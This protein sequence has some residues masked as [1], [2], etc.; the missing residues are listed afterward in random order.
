MNLRALRTL[1][2]LRETPSFAEVAVTSN[3]TLSAVSMQMRSLEEELGV[4]LFDRSFRPPRLTPQGRVVAEQAAL[5]AR[6]E[7]RLRALASSGATLAGRYRMGFVLTA[8]VRLLPGFLAR[9]RDAAPGASF[10]V[11]TGLTEALV[12]GVLHGRLD[13]AVVTGT[14]V[15]SGLEGR[16]LLEEEIVFALPPGMMEPGELPF[17]HF[18]PGAGIGALIAD[19]LEQSALP[20]ARTISLD[21]IEAI[22]ECVRLGIGYTALPRPDI[23]RYADG[24]ELRRFFPDRP[25][26]RSLALVTRTE[27]ATDRVADRL[28]GILVPAVR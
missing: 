27:S 18:M 5:M 9:C 28:A 19:G 20:P 17:L 26:M 7:E 3:Q 10:E 6:E 25:L 16:T 22:V 21:G 1:G 4:A 11:E 12:E 23:L 13:A 14:A 24:L 15:P 2:L 8:S